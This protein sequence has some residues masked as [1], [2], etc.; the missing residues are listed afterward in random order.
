MTP[1]PSAPSS[2][3]P[4]SS[5]I[6]ASP[7]REP[8]SRNPS[9][10]AQAAPPRP[11][12]MSVP[13][14]VSVDCFGPRSSAA[15]CSAASLS[16]A[17]IISTRSPRTPAG[18]AASATSPPAH[19]S[20]CLPKSTSIPA[21]RLSPPTAI[22]AS[23]GTRAAIVGRRRELVGVGVDVE[24]DVGERVVGNERDRV[25]GGR[26]AVPA[27]EPARSRR[28]EHEPDHGR[29]RRDDDGGEDPVAGGRLDPAPARRRAV[30][31]R[32]QPR[33][34]GSA[35]G[36]GVA[37]CLQAP[38]DGAPPVLPAAERGLRGHRRQALPRGL[39]VLGRLLPH[40]AFIPSSSPGYGGAARSR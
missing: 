25:V 14:A 6:A 10:R 11:T 9:S 28:H 8:I 40:R 34:P 32:L 19:G 4:S 5:S 13:A 16:S 31:A 2:A 29:G 38:C 15:N 7:A 22:L 35:A 24:V 18:S 1:V 39:L 3:G 27:R 20:T 37:Q 30:P 23:S 21:T 12:E 33:P 36:A 17:A 26:A